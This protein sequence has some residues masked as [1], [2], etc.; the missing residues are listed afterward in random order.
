MSRPAHTLALA[1]RNDT[2]ALDGAREEAR[3]HL[4]NLGVDETAA[5]AVDLVLEEL[6]GNT[7]RY[8]YAKGTEGSIRIELA[9]GPRDVRIAIRDDARPFDPTRHPDP[10]PAR[11]VRE[12]PVGGRGIAMVRRYAR[13]LRYRRENG[14]N[15]IEVEV[16]RANA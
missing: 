1:L 10:K 12:S 4:E 5:Y 11:T 7:I 6:A 3:R 9:V 16:A 13:A 15:A 8:G 14:A 2:S